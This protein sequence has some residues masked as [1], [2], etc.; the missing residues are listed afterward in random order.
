MSTG[1]NEIYRELG[2][3][4]RYHFRW[5]ERLFGGFLTVLA[6]L[7]VAFY[8]TYRDRGHGDDP[9]LHDWAW[10]VPLIGSVL[11]F[12]F[13]LLDRRCH[14][15][16]LAMRRTGKVLEEKTDGARGVYKT[17]DEIKPASFGEHALSHT[18]VVWALYGVAAVFL[19]V[20]AVSLGAGKRKMTVESAVAR[21]VLLVDRVIPWIAALV[22]MSLGYRLLRKA[23]YDNEQVIGR[24]HGDPWLVPKLGWP[25]LVLMLLGIVGIS[26]LFW[27]SLD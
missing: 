6:V 8:H 17:F 25:G 22:V 9:G 26:V 21:L 14:A 27:R 16:V 19:L 18:R 15:N 4:L 3:F 7:A 2:E 23:V 5:R 12:V 1:W 11:A 10:I 24:A 13:L 20:G